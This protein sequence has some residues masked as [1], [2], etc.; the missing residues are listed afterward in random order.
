MDKEGQPGRT[1][2]EAWTAGLAL[3]IVSA[4]HWGSCTR[5]Q[6]PE[7]QGV[8]RLCRELSLGERFEVRGRD[9]KSI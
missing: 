9:R 6:G 2:E 5:K 4:G 7:S 1:A 3:E 8:A